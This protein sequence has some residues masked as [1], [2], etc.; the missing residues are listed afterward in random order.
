MASYLVTAV[1]SGAT[2]SAVAP[3]TTCVVTGLAGTTTHQFVVRASNA[4]GSSADSAPSA[5]ITAGV[6]GTVP[7]PFSD[8]GPTAYYARAASC[9]LDRSI[10]FNNPYKPAQLVNRA[11]MA[12]FLWRLAGEPTV[13]FPC[14]F[15]DGD[16]IPVYA[17]QAACWLKGEGI[18]TND[19]YKPLDP[20]NRA[21]M[22]SFLYRLGGVIGL[23]LTPEN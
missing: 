22:A 15:V 13:E 1:S 18:T 14:G 7:T 23:W 11:Q 6:C 16:V 20:V 17:Q 10:T 4:G 9:L 2:C 19:P 8:V 5:E 21:Q 3:V 12:G